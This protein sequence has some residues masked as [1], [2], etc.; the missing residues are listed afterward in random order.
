MLPLS[1]R[2]LALRIEIH[3][4]EPSAFGYFNARQLFHLYWLTLANCLFHLA[5]AEIKML[6]FLSQ[7]NV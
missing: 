5:A 7:Q 2:W 1:D 3:G 4:S 6:V